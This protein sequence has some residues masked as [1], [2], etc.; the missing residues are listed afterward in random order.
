MPSPISVKIGRR[1]DTWV[2][3][4][5]CG[6]LFIW[7]RARAAL[8][9]P[10]Q[11]SLRATTPEV[12]GSLP[13]RPRRVLAIKL[14]GLGN[15]A[16]LLP[17]LAALRRGL[18]G[19]Q[20]DF[21]SL[22]ENR[23]LLERSGVVSRVFGL[24]IEGYRGL[25]S[26]LT[27]VLRTI[28]L[29]RYDLVLDF[30]QFIKLSAIIGYLSGAPERIG[31]NTDGQRR[32]WLYTTRV[33]YMDGEH[34]SQIFARPLRAL[35]I[36][37]TPA[38]VS[39]AIKPDEEARSAALLEQHGVSPDHS[40]LV[41]VHVGSGLNFYKLALK[42][43]PTE[44][45]AQ[46]CDALIE[47]HGAAIVFTGKGAEE[48]A[49]ISETVANMKLPSID[50]CDQL[51]IGELLALLKR[52]HLAVSNDTSVMHLAG[53]V[54]TPVVAFFGPTNPS[55]YGP[56]NPQDLVFHRD[57]YCSPCITNYNLKVS[58]CSDP[59]CIREIPAEQVLERIEQNF[60]WQT[61]SPLPADKR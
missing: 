15:V 27:R 30:E 1:I 57:L 42:R 53:L 13:A 54:K 18:P 22:E 29:T 55:Q 38:P 23:A 46:L 11:P 12:S 39:L 43:W 5:I 4:A 47:R 51:S 49:L 2:G 50:T 48:A 14:Y 45:F 35:R 34:M 21:L 26:S 24:N 25:F 6:L 41:A 10:P 36:D 40:P 61:A 31:F 9:G 16:M 19:V 7:S 33:V 37:T 8:G 20:V 60:S 59:V 17:I 32:G 58:Y 44:R 56:T 28:R 52:C 3:L